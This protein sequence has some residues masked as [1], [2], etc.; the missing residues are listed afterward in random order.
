MLIV[1]PHCQYTNPGEAEICEQCGTSLVEQA[2]VNCQTSVPFSEENCPNCGTVTG[3]TWWALIIVAD[4]EKISQDNL[5]PTKYLDNNQ[6]YRI[7][8]DLIARDD[9][10]FSTKVLD[11]EP[12]TL[13][14]FQLSPVQFAD[15]DMTESQSLA[16]R[17]VFTPLVELYLELREK[18]P[19]L[20]PAIHDTWQDE[21]AEYILLDD[22]SAWQHL[23]DIPSLPIRQVLT[24]INQMTALWSEFSQQQ[25]SRTFLD[26]QNL[27]LDEDECFVI[28]EIHKNDNGDDDYLANLGR[29]WQG[30]FPNCELTLQ[31]LYQQLIDG[32]VTTITQLR[33][34]I[35]EIESQLDLTD[36]DLPSLILNPPP[37]EDDDSEVISDPTDG[38]DLPTLVLPMQLLSVTDVAITDIGHQREHNE[39]YFGIVTKTE[40]RENLHKTKYTNQ[41]LYIVCDGMGGH[42]AGEV[43]SRMTVES[44][45]DY[46]HNHWTDQLPSEEVIRQGILLTNQKVYQENLQ[47]GRYGSGR[48]GTTLVMVLIENT[49]AAIAHVGDSRIYHLT[50]KRGLNQ[51]TLDHSVAQQEVLCGVDRE[52]AY[53]RHDAYQL[54]QAIGPRDNSCVHPEIQFIEFKED[55]LLF[56]CS[57]GFSDN[58]FLETLGKTHLL[59]LVGS[60]ANLEVELRQLLE[61]AN[62]HNGHDNLTG[63]L[64]RVKVQPSLERASPNQRFK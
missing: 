18:L 58:D 56:L 30:L 36:Y 16:Q 7:I 27:F 28:Q 1:C 9:V 4:Q 41:G 37:L 3:K 12:L 63:I 48:M 61:L 57:D 5:K 44:L 42:A 43:A 21:T 31:E 54:T 24:Y 10:S 47:Y 35:E 51:L 32:E 20:I 62:Q 29:L 25:L 64:I 39:D 15:E 45:Q 53:R 8:T 23:T 33:T 50:R 14:E 55:T 17:T 34:S 60:K 26:P 22:R 46:F 38:D 59:S 13:P 40:K 6:R 49:K 19:D 2:C 11:C 52:I